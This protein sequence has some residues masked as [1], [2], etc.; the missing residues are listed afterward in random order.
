MVRSRH[1]L[2]ALA[3]RSQYWSTQRISTRIL[4]KI[5]GTVWGI[6]AAL[7]LLAATP[8][9]GPYDS[10]TATPGQTAVKS[11]LYTAIAACVLFPA[12]AP[13]ERTTQYLGGRHARLASNLTYGVFAYQ[14]VALT[15]L[16]RISTQFVFLF[17][18]TLVASIGLA[19]AS[20][21]TMERP[22]AGVRSGGPGAGRTAPSPSPRALQAS[23][24][25]GRPD[26]PGPA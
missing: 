20:F 17:A 24:P 23:R 12:L 26:T 14:V 16:T 25:G 11:L 2:G 22:L 3:G 5:P 18:T 7:L 19:A 8:L 6:A 10:A 21:Y 1:G 15:L 13:S 4:T 9:A